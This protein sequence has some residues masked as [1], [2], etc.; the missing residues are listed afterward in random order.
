MFPEPPQRPAAGSL[1]QLAAARKLATQEPSRWRKQRSRLAPRHDYF[2]RSTSARPVRFAP[3]LK[4]SVSKSNYRLRPTA[5]RVAIA[6]TVE[7]SLVFVVIF[8]QRN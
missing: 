4:S 5:G 1:P 2:P 7:D 6:D 8:R 3:C